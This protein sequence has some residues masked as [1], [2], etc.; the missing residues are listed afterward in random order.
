M[1]DFLYSETITIQIFSSG[2]TFSGRSYTPDTIK[3]AIQ[4]EERNQTSDDG[5]IITTNK[6]LNT[7]E[8][9]S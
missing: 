6:V 2:D 5:Q 7:L 3:G 8:D 9:L 4:S 1:L